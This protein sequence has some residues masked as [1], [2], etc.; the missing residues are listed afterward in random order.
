MK[1]PFI[2]RSMTSDPIID[3]FTFLLHF[4]SKEGLQNNFLIREMKRP[5]FK[6]VKS[7]ILNLDF[8]LSTVASEINEITIHVQYNLDNLVKHIF[9][10]GV[11]CSNTET[12]YIRK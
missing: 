10:I 7:S 9:E 2:S 1:N 6:S 3:N 4:E 11:K 5:P 8:F 12:Y